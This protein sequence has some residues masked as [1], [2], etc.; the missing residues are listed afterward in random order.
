MSTIFTD[1][2]LMHSLILFLMLGSVAGLFAGAALLFRPDWLQRVS[3]HAN[4]WFSTRQMVRPLA[5]AID[6]DNW[7]Y[8]YN[9]LSGT[10]LIAAAFYI[11]YYFTAVFD[12]YSALRNVFNAANIHPEI[13]AGLIDA[14]VLICMM[15][16]VFAGIIGLFFIFRPSMLREFELQ[17]NCKTSLRRRLK[18]L[19]IQRDALDQ[20]V[21]RHMRLVGILMLLGSIY[22]LVVLLNSLKNY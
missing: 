1:A 17:A 6:M 14:L 2:I 13:M 11:V 21:L 20:Y 8:R 16:A 4:R 5:R 15:G 12:K 7:F 10:L 22:T 3:K 18:P 19:E 9:R